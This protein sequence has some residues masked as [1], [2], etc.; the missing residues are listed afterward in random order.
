MTEDQEQA[1]FYQEAY[2]TIPQVRGLLF[3]VPNGGTRNKIEAMKMKATGLT[4]GIPD[5]ICL[6][7]GPIAFEFKTEKGVV[8][9]VQQHIH[10]IWNAAGIPVHVVR[11][12]QTALEILKNHIK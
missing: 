4:A 11:S 8:S 7:N 5:M 6:L 1:K 9:P 10:K 12:W 2:N 3:S